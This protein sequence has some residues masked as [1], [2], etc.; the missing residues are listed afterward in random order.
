M[1]FY[2]GWKIFLDDKFIVYLKGL[3]YYNVDF[4]DEVIIDEFGDIILFVEI[5]V[6]GGD[7]N[8]VNDVVMFLWGL[9][10]FLLFGGMMFFCCK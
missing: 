9:S 5:L 7:G 10:V 8:V 3:D 4:D 1:D 2:G 6:E